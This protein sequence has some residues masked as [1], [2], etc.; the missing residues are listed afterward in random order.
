MIEV[1]VSVQVDDGLAQEGFNSFQI[2]VGLWE[3]PC[4]YHRTRIPCRRQLSHILNGSAV[5]SFPPER[6][7]MWRV[8]ASIAVMPPLGPK[9][10]SNQPKKK[11]LQLA[12]AD[13]CRYVR[14][15]GK[16]DENPSEI[17]REASLLASISFLL[18]IVNKCSLRQKSLVRTVELWPPNC[19][20]PGTGGLSVR[21]LLHP[22]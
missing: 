7:R 19:L 4:R 5:L 2:L 22:K 9:S 8:L 12:L 11:I 10:P 21:N 6:P 17:D 16:I 14:E 3:L 18:M 13:A 20:V 15:R 1:P